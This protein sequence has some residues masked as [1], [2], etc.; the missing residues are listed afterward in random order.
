MPASPH[1]HLSGS[2]SEQPAQSRYPGLSHAPVKF[3]ENSWKQH[4]CIIHDLTH[5]Q[6]DK[7]TA[8]Y[9]HLQTHTRRQKKS[10]LLSGNSLTSSE[11]LTCL[12]TKAPVYTL[13]EEE[14][15]MVQT[16]HAPAPTC[17]AAWCRNAAGIVNRPTTAKRHTSALTYT[18]R[19]HTHSTFLQHQIH[20]HTAGVTLL[21]CTTL[22]CLH[23]KQLI[24]NTRQGL[25]RPTPDR[26]AASA[27]VYTTILI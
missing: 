3:L 2:L 12:Y 24:P 7:D 16:V 11:V 1:D 14:Q 10:R 18:Q 23:K 26:C 21:L 9:M 22:I 5:I 27:Q 8:T 13:P 15:D 4:A 17:R 20:Q 6:T 25:T 19:Q